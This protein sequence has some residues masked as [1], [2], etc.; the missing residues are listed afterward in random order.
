M[1]SSMKFLSQSLIFS[2]LVYR[3]S[4]PRYAIAVMLPVILCFCFSM[5]Q[6]WKNETGTRDRL[7]SL[8]LLC[9]MLYPPF[10][11]IRLV[12]LLIKKDRRW[13][14]AKRNYDTNI[15]SIGK[16]KIWKKVSLR[17]SIYNPTST[18]PNM[19]LQVTSIS[20]RFTVKIEKFW[21]IPPMFWWVF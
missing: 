15:S 7:A 8:P 13:L 3:R 16:W 21:K 10:V 18:V 9:L 17:K 5:N 14:E 19:A 20:I 11:A 2:F 6:W 4:H 12:Y 1:R